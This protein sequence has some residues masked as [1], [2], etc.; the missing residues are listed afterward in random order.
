MVCCD[1]VAFACCMDEVIIVGGKVWVE[2]VET[3]G[4]GKTGD[5]VIF[6]LIFGDFRAEA[7]T[8]IRIII[9]I[10]VI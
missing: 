3:D 7:D 4:Y 1:S 5:R 6:F 9:R 2:S 10:L 8:L